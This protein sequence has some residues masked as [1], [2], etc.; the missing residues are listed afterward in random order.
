[1]HN[2][3]LFHYFTFSRISDYV[4]IMHLSLGGFRYFKLVP[5]NFLY[6]SLL[7]CMYK[8]LSGHYEEK[9]EKK[10]KAHRINWG[11][12]GNNEFLVSQVNT[13]G[14]HLLVREKSYTAEV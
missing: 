8:K 5:L 7:C 14:S 4:Q 1:M 13:G 6:L 3:I 11:Q 9:K 10:V 12:L 2:S